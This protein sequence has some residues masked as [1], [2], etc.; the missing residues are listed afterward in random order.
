MSLG[1][2]KFF[3]FAMVIGN[4]ILINS[5]ISTSI[6]L[7]TE[8]QRITDI[9]QGYQ[10]EVGWRTYM[11]TPPFMGDIEIISPGDFKYAY[12]LSD[13]PSCMLKMDKNPLESTH[14]RLIPANRSQS[15]RT[16]EKLKCVLYSSDNNCGN[17]LISFPEEYFLPEE[18]MP[19]KNESSRPLNETPP[20]KLEAKIN[21]P[22]IINSFA[23]NSTSPR[24][25]G[26]TIGWTVNASDEDDDSLLYR[27][28]VNGSN[29]TDW[30]TK[31]NWQWDTSGYS[32]ECRVE[33]QVRDIEN[34]D[35]NIFNNSS[36]N[37]F[38]IENPQLMIEHLEIQPDKN[39]PQPAG[40]VI[41][42]N[43]SSSSN[44]NNAQYD[45][46][47]NG[48]LVNSSCTPVLTWLANDSYIGTNK[49]EIK[50]RNINNGEYII[51]NDS[52]TFSY[53]I[54]ILVTNG[55][56][57]Q[58][59]VRNSSIF[60]IFIDRSVEIRET[61]NISRPFIKIIGRSDAVIRPIGINNA[62][63]VFE[64]NFKILNLKLEGFTRD[65][66]SGISVFASNCLIENVTINSGMA[67]Y[68]EDSNNTSINSCSFTRVGGDDLYL[69][70]I[71]NS[72]FINVGGNTFGGSDYLF[73]LKDVSYCEIRNNTLAISGHGI[74]LDGECINI[75][76]SNNSINKT[77]YPNRNCH[78]I[79][80]TNGCDNISII[81]NT[82]DCW[83]Y[84]DSNS[85]W[86][87]N[88]WIGLPC[89]QG[90]MS[91]RRSNGSSGCTKDGEAKC[92]M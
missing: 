6:E 78:S 67:I 45:L 52:A 36:V 51:D 14:G 39:S 79:D 72:K 7:S 89:P 38:L 74:Q 54:G 63:D 69:F 68:I 91:I 66:S 35:T 10:Q 4:Y 64:E 76:I 57:L 47:I 31:N 90:I 87:E 70:C 11:L 92:C 55:E 44:L 3:A 9:S 37:L 15:V 43:A 18:E 23:P 83:A 40:T 46:I 56:D 59:A 88:C 29:K 71:N 17:V 24:E 62:I 85:T 49:I 41:R 32:G 86:K 42:F 34:P 73:M 8:W 65:R 84:D 12:Q 30:M 21:R 77:R 27:F 75:T 13:S 1:W 26:C 25:A 33:V 53:D 48:K 80:I 19:A 61:L 16:G 20:P 60:T 82:I 81:N 28:L 50:T 58:N 22:P 5:S 2:L